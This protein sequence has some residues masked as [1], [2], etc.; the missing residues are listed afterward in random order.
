MIQQNNP[1]FKISKFYGASE[2]RNYKH[3]LKASIIPG[4]PPNIMIY[5]VDFTQAAK[6]QFREKD[7]TSGPLSWMT[8]SMVRVNNK[9]TIVEI[10]VAAPHT[11]VCSI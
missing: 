9:T 11:T 5:S 6:A 4:N 10:H 7:Q 2:K 8:V 1:M 3:T